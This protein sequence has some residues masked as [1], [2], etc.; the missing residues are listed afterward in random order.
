MEPSPEPAAPVPAPGRELHVV[1][2][3][4]AS[5]AGAP[6]RERP[7]TAPAAPVPALV[8]LGLDAGRLVPGRVRELGPA[9]G[10]DALVDALDQ[11][12]HVLAICPRWL[13]PPARL[14]L[15]TARAAL[16]STRVAIH[17]TALPPLA[18]TALVALAAR[19]AEHAPAPGLLAGALP[20]LESEL[21]VLAWLGSLAR[22]ET[23]APT[24]AQHV[25]SLAPGTAYAVASWPRPAVH[26]LTKTSP[27]VPLPAIGWPLDVLIARAARGD[28]RWA[29]DHVVRPLRPRAVV[30]LDPSP[31]GPRFWGTDRLTEAVALP[32]DPRAALRRALRGRRP[33]L[34]RWCGEAVA[35][36][37]CP[38]CGMSRP[39]PA[40]HDPGKDPR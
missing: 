37:P 3:G 33:R 6:A 36:S 34:C 14:A 30:E 18:A 10:L 38:F 19:V 27:G 25:M 15:E 35:G 22:L 16:D 5:A 11:Q 40:T 7:T 21:L 23:P 39:T 20:G 24:V 29:A 4:R 12:R 1:P 28:E 13:G 17:A 2:G 31:A 26:R 9:P 8:A 32:A